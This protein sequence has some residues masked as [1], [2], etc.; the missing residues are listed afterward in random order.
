MGFMFFNIVSMLINASQRGS[1]NTRIAFTTNLVS[2]LVNII[3]NY[4]LIGGK[5]GF[6]ALGVRGAAIATV[7]GTVVAFFMS[8][9]SLFKKDSF[10]QI[11]YII[12][13]K[14]KGSKILAKKILKFA[15][16]IFIENIAMRLGFLIT[17]LMAASLGT[18]DFA[19]HQAGMN[20]LSLS[21]A[22]ADG[23]QVSA[24]ALTGSSLGKGDKEKARKYGKT[25]QKIGLIISVGMS[26]FLFI[27]G[28]DIFSLFFKESAN[29]EK[30][31]MISRFIMVITLFQISQIIYGGCLRSAGDV[32]YALFASMTSVTIIRSL[33]TMI[34][35]GVL[36]MGLFG[37]WI[38]VLS[39][40]FSRYMFMSTRFRKGKW[41]D[42]KI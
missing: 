32:K 30:G 14:I 11:P 29:I 28:K 16:N 19:V 36:K 13:K 38:G 15:A 42:I 37:I 17:A 2:S 6:Q 9:R 23:M 39:D 27:F 34:L 31:I 8:L 1:G 3:F 25:C 22:F 24:V 26:I 40:Q 20:V 33:V 35:V 10:V 12:N 41:V 4:I 18:D 5:F 7:M 21:F